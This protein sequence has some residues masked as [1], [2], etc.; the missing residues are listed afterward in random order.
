VPTLRARPGFVAGYWTEPRNDQSFAF[1][2]FDDEAAARAAAPA[3]G[4]AAGDRVTIEG[5]DFRE[6]QA[7]PDTTATQGCRVTRDLSARESPPTAVA[8]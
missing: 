1:L 7:T 3:P 5:V 8:G 6:I 4:A 2:V